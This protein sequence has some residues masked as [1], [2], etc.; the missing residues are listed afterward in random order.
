ME[1]KVF[2]LVIPQASNQLFLFPLLFVVITLQSEVQ[3]FHLDHASFLAAKSTGLCSCKIIILHSKNKT[4][5]EQNKNCNNFDLLLHTKKVAHIYLQPRHHH[6]FP[7][8]LPHISTNLQFKY[9]CFFILIALKC[10]F[11]LISF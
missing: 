4:T 10:F 3:M 6:F 5:K 7:F 8:V 1:I 2:L 11:F 9:I